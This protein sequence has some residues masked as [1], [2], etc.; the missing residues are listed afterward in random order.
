MIKAVN[1]D[2]VTGT[3]EEYSWLSNLDKNTS[4]IDYELL[5]QEQYMN[6]VRRGGVAGG[7]GGGGGARG[8]G[9]GEAGQYK[10]GWYEG[11]L[12]GSCR[13]IRGVWREVGTGRKGGK[14]ARGVQ[15]KE[16]WYEGR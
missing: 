6:E 3:P 4:G 15:H 5:M 16:G 12:S 7:R 2:E 1:P 14:M 8:G 10:E 11:A 13:S 9:G